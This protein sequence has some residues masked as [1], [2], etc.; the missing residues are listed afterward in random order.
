MAQGGECRNLPKSAPQNWVLSIA[1]RAVGCERIPAGTVSSV[2]TAAPTHSMALN[3]E[4]IVMSK[5][6][7]QFAVGIAIFALALPGA[8]RLRAQTGNTGSIS[9]TVQDPTGA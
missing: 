7:N 4:R 2:R 9:I 6:A 5:F 1:R 3:Q 8:S